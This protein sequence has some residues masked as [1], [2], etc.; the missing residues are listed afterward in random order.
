MKTC[1]KCGETKPLEE[2]YRDASRYGGRMSHC[3]AC[4]RAKVRARDKKKPLIP[5]WLEKRAAYNRERR[6][7]ETSRARER[8]H[9]EAYRERY[10]VKD[11][12]KRAVK[13]AISRGEL[14]RPDVC[15]DCGGMPVPRSDGRAS[16]HAHQDDYSRP[17]DVRWLCQSCH[18]KQHRALP[19]TPEEPA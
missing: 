10:P 4:T 12:A 2:F 5:G 7:Y 15:E 1:P 8:R 11:A 19:L 9:A 14:S 3:A 6:A 17:L 16:I 18:N 13:A